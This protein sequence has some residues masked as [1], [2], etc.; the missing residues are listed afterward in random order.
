MEFWDDEFYVIFEGRIAVETVLDKESM[1]TIDYLSKGA[2]VRP[3]H[4]LVNRINRVKYSV[5]E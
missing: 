5:L 3:H 4:F 1:V 2:I